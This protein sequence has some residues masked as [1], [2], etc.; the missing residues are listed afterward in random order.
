MNLV[1]LSETDLAEVETLFS[2]FHQEY[3]YFFQTQTR[4]VIKPA[5][6]YLHGQLFTK[7]LFAL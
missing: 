3:S 4:S 1:S 5:V 2:D 6:D 7:Y